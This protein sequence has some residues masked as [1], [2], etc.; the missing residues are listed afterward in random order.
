[1]TANNVQFRQADFIAAS[2][3]NVQIVLLEAVAVVAVVLF[4][5]LLNGR[6][7]FISLTAIPLSVL[8]TVVVFQLLGLSINTMTLGGLTIAVGE[9]VDDAVADVEN[10]FRRLRE[11]RVRPDPRPAI[12]VVAKASQEVRSGIVYA[13][14]IVILV[15]VPLF[16]L[17]GIEGRLFAPLGVAYIVSILASLA[18][19][20]TV[21]PVPHH[22][23][24]RG[25]KRMDHGDSALVRVLKRCGDERVLLGLRPRAPYLCV[26]GRGRCGAHWRPCH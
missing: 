11:N 19:S 18:V 3:G 21:T 4:M 20:I 7:T 9:L 24:P 23:L 13:T 26:G 1:M 10:V 14:L 25:M 12:I 17:T 5:F 6:T 22:L 8:I 2:I 15:F 16:A